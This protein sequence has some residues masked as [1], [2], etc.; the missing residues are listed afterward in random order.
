MRFSEWE[1]VYSLILS[2][3]GY[4]RTDDEDSAR[5]LRAL[6]PNAEHVSDEE[7]E[8]LI[9][10]EVVIFGDADTLGKSLVSFEASGTLIASGSATSK[11]MAAGI[12]PDIVVTDLDGDVEAQKEA[13]RMGALTLIHAHGDNSESIMKHAKDFKGKVVLTTQSVP[14][15]VVRNFGGF[16]DGDR[17]VCLA[18]HFGAKKINLVGF[19]YEN[20]SVKEGSDRNTKKR[21]LAWA[22]RIIEDL[23]TPGV[24]IVRI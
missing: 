8:S 18:R 13:S 10:E 23:N 24:E 16:T 19:D 1:P 3:M 17:S 4:D 11:V 20:P 7:I 12:I 22:K 6:M 2:D 15:H 9:G 14:D 5:L 21:K